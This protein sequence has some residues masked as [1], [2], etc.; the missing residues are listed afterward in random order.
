[1][2][3]SP[4]QSDTLHYWCY[5]CEEHVSTETLL[6]LS[7]VIYNECKNGFVET[8]GVMLTA[9]EPRSADQIDEHSLVYMLTRRLRHITQPSSDNEDLPSPPPDHASEDDFLRIVLDGWN[10]DEDED[11][12]ENDG[13]GEE[14]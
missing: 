12:N 6:D 7:D 8:I 11:M 5:H 9:L 13:E 2:D 3:E 1:M 4:I 14:Q 10:N